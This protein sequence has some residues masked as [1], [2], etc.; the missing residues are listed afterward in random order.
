MGRSVLIVVCLMALFACH[1]AKPLPVKPVTHIAFG[2]CN[3]HDKDQKIW[4]SIIDAN[5]DLFVWLG[6]VIYGDSE[7]LPM[8]WS[9]SSLEKMAEKL[10]LQKTSPLY[11]QLRSTTPIVGIWVCK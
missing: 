2:S 1:F 6:D 4:K 3:E 10:E 9:S 5:P 7:S 8:V 11:S